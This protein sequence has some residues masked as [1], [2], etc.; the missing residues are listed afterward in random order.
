MER[1]LLDTNVVS[2]LRK[3]GSGKANKAVAR[4]S[5][6][7]NAGD[8]YLSVISLHEIEI[9]VLQKE[10]RDKAQ[11]SVLRRWMTERLLPA[12]RGRILPVTQDIALTA[13]AWHVPVTRSFQ[14]SLIAATAAVHNLTVATRNV[15]DFRPFDCRIHDPFTQK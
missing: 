3:V 7:L 5:S 1:Y 10:R 4:W 8:L 9:G 2:E 15:Q 13:S 14:D 12:F 11:G 6:E